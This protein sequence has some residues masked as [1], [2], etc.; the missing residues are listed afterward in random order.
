MSAYKKGIMNRITKFWIRTR[1][2]VSKLTE[3]GWTASME[4]YCPWYFKPLDIAYDF[5]YGKVTLLEE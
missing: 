1:P 5:V 3:Q 4:F 2:V